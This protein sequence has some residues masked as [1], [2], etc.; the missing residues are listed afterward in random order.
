MTT[1]G[2]E[3]SLQR[4]QQALDDLPE[5]QLLAV[6]SAALE[7]RPALAKVRDDVMATMYTGLGA[8]G[9]LDWSHATAAHIAGQV[10]IEVAARHAVLDTPMLTA[11]HVADL[12]RSANNN[13]RE[14]GSAMRRQGRA[15]G[16]EVGGR[17]VFPAFQFD[18]AR[19]RLRPV[20]AEINRRLG[21]ASDP[22]GVAS[23]WLAP[24][25][26]RDDDVSPADLVAKG[27]EEAVR[28]LAAAETE[29][30]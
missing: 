1:N 11:E 9:T 14:A 7:H 22:W 15:V 28:A 29:G 4:V 13:R 16:V 6:F 25:V 23:W 26:W 18:H 10:Q 19:A 27:D 20:V 21:A 30:Y 12:V 5:E 8:A 3:R 24:S 2:T 17:T